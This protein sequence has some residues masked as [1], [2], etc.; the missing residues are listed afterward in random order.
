MNVILESV[1]PFVA[2]LVFL[3]VVHELGHFVTAKLSGVKVLEFGIGYPPR[4]WGFKFRDTEYTINILPLGG[5]VRLLGEEDPSDPH[6]LAAQ[7]AWKR[8][9]VMVSGSFMNFL[10]AVA[11][12]TVALMIPREL[13]AGR[14]QISQVVPGS[15]AAEAGLKV[16]DIIEKIDG[17]DVKSTPEASYNIRLHLGERI[18]IQVK[19]TDPLT[20]E[21][22]TYTAWVKPRWAPPPFVY[23]VQ[24]GDTVDK[25]ASATGFDRFSVRTAAGIDFIVPAGKEL[26]IQDAGET[27]RYTP[28]EDE[29]VDFIARTLRV[30]EDQVALAAGL[31]DQ[32]ALKPGTE[33]KFQQGATGIRIGPQYPFTETRSEDPLSALRLGVRQTFDSLKLARNEV[34]AWIK[35][36]STPAVSGPIGIAQTT[37]EVV[38]QAGWKSLVDFAALLS[39]NLAIL[40][41][42]PLPMLDGGRMAFV[43]IEV[44][45][46]GRRIAPAK[47]ALIHLVGFAAMLI[48]VVVLSYFDIARIV[49]GDSIFR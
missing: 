48:L 3:V 45:R 38:E 7:P 20:G 2:I 14:A 30:S 9:I 5:F 23:T 36:A 26:V 28:R 47:E 16:G 11:L 1:L 22:T 13:P 25:V 37:G 34:I 4:L 46:R 24:P 19:R 35:G 12:F 29:T 43:L 39:V 44:M 31:P 18:P 40:N 21:S 27:I 10:L 41:I 33:L 42:L 49:R 8:L 32:N 17:R 15:P 6:S